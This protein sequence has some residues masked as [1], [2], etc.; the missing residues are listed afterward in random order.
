MD[1]YAKLSETFKQAFGQ[2]MA[3]PLM[4]GEVKE[5]TGDTCTV[6]FGGIEITDVRLKVQIGGE[7][8]RLIQFPAIG[9]MV[10]CGSLTGDFKDLVVIK[11]ER[12]AKLQYDENGLSIEI[13]SESG[14]VKIEN[15]NVSLKDLFDDL[16]S[17]IQNLKVFTPAGPSGNPLPDTI[18][19]LNTLQT[20]INQLLN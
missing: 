13:D 4:V 1:K 5:I 14:K 12:I 19:S 15:E 9:K 6:D 18:A 20:K 3:M 16:K 7:T 11:A 17:I 10:L 2:R 8:D